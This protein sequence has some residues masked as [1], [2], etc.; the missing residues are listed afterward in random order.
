[1]TWAPRGILRTTS[2]SVGRSTTKRR[3]VDA[4]D[5]RP[6]GRPI[7]SS[8]ATMPAWVWNERPR[9]QRHQVAPL[10]GVDEQDPLPGRQAGPGARRRAGVTPR[11]STVRAWRGR[12]RRSRAAGRAPRARSRPPRRGSS[13]P[14]RTSQA[15]PAT[16]SQIGS[17]PRPR[18]MA[19]RHQDAQ[20]PVHRPASD[21]ADLDDGRA[22]PTASAS[23]QVGD[24]A[25]PGAPRPRPS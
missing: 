22:G 13:R 11:R 20:Q 19:A 25:R 9:M 1:M 18:R 14:R 3:P 8:W 10:L 7:T 2:A 5:R 17:P 4:A 21:L 16:A 12:R 24:Q 6:L 15:A 23:E